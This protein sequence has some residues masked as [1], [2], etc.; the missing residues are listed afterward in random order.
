[1]S[2]T[3]VHNDPRIDRRVHL[4]YKDILLVPYDKPGFPCSVMS[5]NDPNIRSKVTLDRLI[6]VPLIS[7][8]MDSITDGRM[9]YALDRCGALGI[10]TRY[11]GEKNE[12][13]IQLETMRVLRPKIKGHLAC[14]IGMRSND[15]DQ[16]AELCDAGVDIIC[17]DV[18][19]GNHRLM[20]KALNMLAVLKDRYG[21]SVIA[22]NVASAGAARNLVSGGADAIKVGIGPGGACTTRRVTGF[23]VPQFTAILDC[24]HYVQSEAP[25]IKIIADGG[26][27]SSGDVVKALWAGADTVMAGWIFAG[28][29]ECP[30]PAGNS[31]RYRGMSCR[32]VNCR[33]DVAPEGVDMEVSPKGPVKDTVNRYTA[34]I[35]AGLALGN[36]MNLTE[37]RKNVRAVRVST[38]SHDESEPAQ[39]N[40]T[41]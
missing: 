13:E 21:I 25:E 4:S 18:A 5:R 27:R 3:P 6:D 14:A 37:F 7:S 39:D 29:N 24:S 19:N 20:M 36:A 31:Y 34:A 1:M 33:K 32:T 28:H 38:M 9:I 12:H 15:P 10:H 17:V 41:E 23:G 26:I 22:G 40:Y 11:I 30:R 35:K 8:P 16:V 2:D